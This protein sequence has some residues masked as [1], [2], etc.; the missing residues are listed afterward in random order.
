MAKEA[1]ERLL[2]D[3]RGRLAASAKEETRAWFEE[4]ARHLGRWRGNEADACGRAVREAC[5][6]SRA[7]ASAEPASVSGEARYRAAFELMRSEFCDDKLAGMILFEVRLPASPASDPNPFLRSRALPSKAILFAR[8]RA[9]WIPRRAPRRAPPPRVRALTPSRAP[10]RP[11]PQEHVL[12]D[13][14]AAPFLF[15]PEPAGARTDDADA[16]GR[17]LTDGFPALRDARLAFEDPG[18]SGVHDWST[19]D[20]MAA[21]VLGPYVAAHPRPRDAAR[22]LMTWAALPTGAATPWMRRAGLTSFVN[23][24]DGDGEPTLSPRMRKSSSSTPPPSSSRVE[25]AEGRARGGDALFGDGFVLELA[26]ACGAALGVGDSRVPSSSSSLAADA[27]LPDS[28]QD[29]GET[30]DPTGDPEAWVRVGARWMLSLCVRECERA[31]AERRAPAKTSGEENATRT[32]TSANATTP[33]PSPMPT[34][35][36]SKRRRVGERATPTKA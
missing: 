28:N 33:S 30:A 27:V 18:D 15:P 36:R 4:T 16:S 8:P 7:D 3:V 9:R 34:K 20:W 5:E 10:L 2:E 31:E 1:S 25:P 11:S 26:S 12:P 22:A 35:A 19:C 29:Q 6:A 14:S 21:K 24:V 23:L 17:E 13:P 32:T